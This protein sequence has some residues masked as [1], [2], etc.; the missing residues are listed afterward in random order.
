MFAL[1]Q[2]KH[3][4]NCKENSKFGTNAS[5]SAKIWSSTWCKMLHYSNAW[6]QQTGKKSRFEYFKFSKMLWKVSYYSSIITH[7]H[8]AFWRHY[9]TLLG[10]KNEGNMPGPIAWVGKILFFHYFIFSVER[11]N[12]SKKYY[13]FKLFFHHFEKNY[14]LD[15]L[16]K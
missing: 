4:W 14:F 7:C 10:P 15:F 16:K 1:Y 5:L 3:Y 2:G 12:N 9:L 11:N 6:I 13:F 8:W